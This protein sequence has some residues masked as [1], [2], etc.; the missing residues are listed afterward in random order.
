MTE[1]MIPPGPDELTQVEAEIPEWLSAAFEVPRREGVVRSNDCD[2]RYFAWGDPS[3]PPLIFV[4][5]FL[6]HRRCFAFIAPLLAQDYYCIAYDMSGMGDSGH[7]ESYPDDVRCQELFDVAEEEGAFEHQ[8]KPTIIAHSYGGTVGLLAVE[9]DADAFHGLII[10][11]LLAMRPDA[12]KAFFENDRGP[13][14]GRDP[15]RPNKVY[16]TYEDARQRF[17]LAPPQSVAVPALFDY[18]AYHSLKEVDG[19]WAWKF[20]P[21]VFNRHEESKARPHLSAGR[22]VEAKGRKAFLFGEKSR[23]FTP[24][25]AAYLR[26]LGET[27]MP[28]IGVPEAHHHLFLDQ[29]IAFVV[30]LR[31][32][33]AMWD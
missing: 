3:K 2:I 29:P 6:A 4:H 21:S 32:I 18:M 11:D 9:R 12:L 23:L 8:V 15:N 17:V 26:E 27:K 25:S 14:R 28:I 20:H 24:D 30:A 7:R 16:P 10:C 31:T 5:G 13:G 1:T 19:G 22:I 33:L